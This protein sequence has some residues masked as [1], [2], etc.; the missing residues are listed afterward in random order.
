MHHD[1]LMIQTH[2]GSQLGPLLRGMNAHK[3]IYV[4]H[5]PMV[6]STPPD[7]DILKTA[8][9]VMK[10]CRIYADVIKFNHALRT[11]QLDELCSFLFY[12]GDPRRSITEIVKGHGYEL[13]KALDY[14]AFRLQ[15]LS[16]MAKHMP[17]SMI[18]TFDQLNEDDAN[19]SVAKFLR[20]KSPLM[21]SVEGEDLKFPPSGD[22]IADEACK[23]YDKYLARMQKYINRGDHNVCTVTEDQN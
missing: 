5:S 8:C 22:R 9:G 1:Y 11:P 10:E 14:Y 12:L 20:L 13:N 19:A 2:L 3:E 15:R 7:L 21:F 23:V 4:C 6:Y 18:L 17:N 16:S